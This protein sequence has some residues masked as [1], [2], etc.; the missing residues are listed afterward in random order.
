MI[1]EDKPGTYLLYAN[2]ECALVVIGILFALQVN[3]WNEDKNRD[4]LEISILAELKENLLR[5]IQDFQ[6]NI[7]YYEKSVRSGRIIIEALMKRLP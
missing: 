4:A 7:N 1:I 3:Y 6:I 2:G 5:D